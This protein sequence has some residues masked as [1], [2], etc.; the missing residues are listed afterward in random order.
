[1][2]RRSSSAAL[3][4]AAATAFA[5]AGASSPARTRG[6]AEVSVNEL[7]VI[8]THNSYHRE[9]SGPE[10]DAYDALVSTPGDYD[11]FL[12]YSHATLARQLGRQGARGIELDL[13][14]DPDGGLYAEPLVRRRLR[15]G[16]LA[17]RE[18]RRPGT[19]V[20]HIPDL[21]Y[22]TTCV[23]FVRC[24]RQVRDWSYAHPRHVPVAIL[25]E[26]KRSDA[27][28]VALGG[29]V[30]PAWDGTA[31]DALDD[32][33]RSVFGADEAITP[34]DVRRPGETLE[35]SVLRHGWPALSVSRGKVL[36]LLDNDPGPIRDAYVAGRPGL[37]GRMLFTNSLPGSDD[38]AFVKRNEPRGLATAEIS[39]LVRRGYYV[40]T[41]SDLPLQTVWAN[42]RSMFDAALA[43]GA[44][45]ISTDFP[46]QGMSARYG[47]DLFASLP[48]RGGPA[49]CNPVNA[50]RACR[51][52]RLTAR[53]RSR[54]AAQAA[55][56]D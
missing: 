35:R 33:I 7:Q 21:D 1:M 54:V 51:D 12:R 55:P 53:R 50:P 16:P 37:E 56:R 45:L 28:A 6:G 40:R 4:L 47:S 19:K 43:G 30:A 10:Q 5:A 38:A 41:R 9:L 39:E 8:G 22:E 32:E 23:R 34:D 15:L 46:E 26:L 11:A 3:L 20:L 2:R 49:R 44:Q 48:G 52:E 24:L 36:F 31:L 17:D 29:V 25:L 42:D 14:G 18:W 13:L 27:R